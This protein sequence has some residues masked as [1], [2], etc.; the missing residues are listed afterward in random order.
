[1]GDDY[2]DVHCFDFSSSPAL[3]DLMRSAP[4]ASVLR[5]RAG[6]E[7]VHWREC[8]ARRL[9]IGG[10]HEQHWTWGAIRRTAIPFVVVALVF[11]WVV[12]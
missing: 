2:Q 9:L 10:V 4:A 6:F 5:V 12:P 11:S 1:M 7:D 3:A 8:G